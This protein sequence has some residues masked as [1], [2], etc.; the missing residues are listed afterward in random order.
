MKPYTDGEI[1]KLNFTKR[2][3]STSKI[4]FR[5]FGT[6]LLRRIVKLILGFHITYFFFFSLKIFSGN[7]LL[8]S[9]FRHFVQ[10]L[11]D[12]KSIQ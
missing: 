9:N 5:N 12:I 6:P 2:F 7:H 1:I 11:R 3:H 4:T 10:T 8:V